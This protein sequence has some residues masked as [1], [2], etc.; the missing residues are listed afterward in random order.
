MQPTS[1][2]DN[3]NSDLLAALTALLPKGSAQRVLVYVESHDDISFWRG[4]LSPFE[5]QGV[6][7]DIQLPSQN[8]LQKGK[9]A[10]LE[11][12]DRVG[13]NLVLCVDSDYDYLLQGNSAT[14]ELINEN[15]YIFQTYAYSIENL[16]CYSEGLHLIL[17]QSSKN[18]TKIIDFNELM[19]LYSSIAYKLFLWSVHFSIKQDTTSFTLTEFCD[20]IKVLEKVQVSDKLGSAIKGLNDRVAIKLSELERNHPNDVTEIEL[21]AKKLEQLGVLPINTYLF[22]QG[23]TIKDNVVLMF[24]NPIFRHLKAEKEN[25][26]KV[27]AKHNEEM[28]NQLKLYKKQIVAIDVAIDNNTEFKTC[29]LYLKIESDINEYIGKF[30][31]TR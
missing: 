23:H 16:K 12:A 14:S 4:I 17:S 31:E 8:T 27:N 1:L 18:D 26:I 29:H 19:Q 20:T 22:I 11:F 30:Q 28:L 15:Q 13:P 25:E 21:L 7:F 6:N 5:R 3:L 2:L 9:T 10:V 24:L